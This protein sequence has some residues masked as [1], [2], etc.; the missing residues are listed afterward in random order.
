VKIVTN[1]IQTAHP[2]WKLPERRVNKFVKRTMNKHK[3]PAGA[4]DDQTASM[5][6][7]RSGR[8]FFGFLSPTKRTNLLADPPTA[9]EAV[10]AAEPESS[11]NEAA[12]P[13][14]IKEEEGE[15]EQ[16]IAEVASKDIA[17]ETDNDVVESSNDCW[18][19]QCSVM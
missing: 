18:G 17:Y 8:G 4:D 16:V 1:K 15:P 11:V 12:P 14:P 10:D 7:Q 19:L 5:Y 6:K 2:D 13:T 9:Q 3:N